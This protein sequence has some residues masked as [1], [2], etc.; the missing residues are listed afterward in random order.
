MI[1]Q[2]SLMLLIVKILTEIKSKKIRN[3]PEKRLI[4]AISEGK[5]AFL[6]GVYELYLKEAQRRGISLSSAELET[7]VIKKQ[8]EDLVDEG[9]GGTFF[10]LGI[11]G[12]IAAC[13]LLFK[14]G[15]DGEPVYSSKSRKHGIIIFSIS[16]CVLIF[17]LFAAVIFFVFGI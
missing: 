5:E 2:G 6:P 11:G 3:M 10:G 9:Y 15:I 8:T 4:D 17:V 14:K 1:F 16:I 7:L 12:I 13:K